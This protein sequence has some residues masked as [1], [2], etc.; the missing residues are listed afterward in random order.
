MAPKRGRPRSEDSADPKLNRRRE[1]TRERVR[2]C[3]ERKR[4]EAASAAQAP[5]VEQLRLEDE[6]VSRLPLGE[7][8]VESTPPE[9]ELHIQDLNLAT[10]LRSALQQ[11]AAAPAGDDNAAYDQT[12]EGPTIGL[13]L[14]NPLEQSTRLPS[15]RPSAV[16][17]NSKKRKEPPAEAKQP[18]LLQ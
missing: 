9:L 17:V 3:R 4:Q 14:Q 1:M 8:E 2:R 18:I 15:E 13:P 7:N 6:I 5:T 12:C 10:D 16:S 11:Q